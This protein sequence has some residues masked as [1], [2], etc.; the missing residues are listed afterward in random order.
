MCVS[1]I[2]LQELEASY[3]QEMREKELQ[4]D[5][6]VSVLV[7]VCASWHCCCLCSV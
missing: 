3:Q 6:K 4:V 7:N 5:K 2:V 1:F